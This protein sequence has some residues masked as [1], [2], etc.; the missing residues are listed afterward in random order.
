MKKTRTKAPRR[1]T[2]QL[3][4]LGVD[5]NDD[6]LSVPGYDLGWFR[7][8]NS[9]KALVAATGDD[10]VA[11]KTKDDYAVL[12]SLADK[13]GFMRAIKQALVRQA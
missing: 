13:D 2:R 3:M 10:I 4:V 5:P 7:T 8:A 12:V 1:K 6:V 9:G 11:F